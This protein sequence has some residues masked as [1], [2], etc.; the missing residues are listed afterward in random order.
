MEVK[1]KTVG[2]SQV[3]V[4]GAECLPKTRYFCCSENNDIS[5][6]T[7]IGKYRNN[8]SMLCMGCLTL[9]QNSSGIGR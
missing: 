8:C 4:K 7:V 2:S 5:D 6:I 9:A 1:K 3:S